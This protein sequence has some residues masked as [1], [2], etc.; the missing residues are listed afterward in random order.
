MITDEGERT[1]GDGAT[2]STADENGAIAMET[3]KE[4]NKQQ[5]GS[6]KEQVTDGDRA[7]DE[8]APIK[9]L[10]NNEEQSVNVAEKPTEKD[11]RSEK[12]EGSSDENENPDGQGKKKSKRKGRGRQSRPKPATVV[13]H[14]TNRNPFLQK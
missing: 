3:A 8:G 9:R 14:A 2:I 1:T 11:V 5:T 10:K 13:S 7:P 12:A 6:G 4:T